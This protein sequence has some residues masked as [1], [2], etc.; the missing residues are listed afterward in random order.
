MWDNLEEQQQEEDEEEEEVRVTI[1][2]SFSF[3]LLL[4]NTF[5]VVTQKSHIHRL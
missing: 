2:S 3:T 1:N 4:Q 5:P